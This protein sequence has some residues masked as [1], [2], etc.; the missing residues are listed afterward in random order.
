[1][2]AATTIARDVLCLLIKEG[3]A[4][5]EMP[6][7]RGSSGGRERERKRE[8]ELESCKLVGSP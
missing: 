2:V 8:R 3:R 4:Q 5:S 6:R 1:M 7:L